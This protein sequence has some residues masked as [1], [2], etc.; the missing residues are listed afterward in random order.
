MQYGTLEKIRQ[1]PYAFADKA[2]A[3]GHTVRVLGAGETIEV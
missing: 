2:T 1:N 3:A